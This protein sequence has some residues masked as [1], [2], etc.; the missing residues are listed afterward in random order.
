VHLRLHHLFCFSERGAALLRLIKTP[1]ART[2]NNEKFK[3]KCSERSAEKFHGWSAHATHKD[4][5]KVM[6][7]LGRWWNSRGKTKLFIKNKSGMLKAATHCSTISVN[8]RFS[9]NFFSTA[10]SII[11]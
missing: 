5:L 2:P 8:N 9:W 3:H 10:N 6:H 1:R 11:V 4:G 7:V